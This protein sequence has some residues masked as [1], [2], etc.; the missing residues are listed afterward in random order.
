MSKISLRCLQ[1]HEKAP[2]NDT[3]VDIEYVEINFRLMILPPSLPSLPSLPAP[4]LLLKKI[5]K[6]QKKLPRKI[7]SAHAKK[8][9]NALTTFIFIP[10]SILLFSFIINII[11]II[12]II[13]NTNIIANVH[14]RSEKLKRNDISTFFFS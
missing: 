10:L 3:E 7:I 13:V 12:I 11:I 9:Q 1:K 8:N 4:I 6:S 2:F 5:V 14:F